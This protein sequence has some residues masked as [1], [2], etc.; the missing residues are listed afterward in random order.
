MFSELGER[1]E[2]EEE[3]EEEEEIAFFV[4]ISGRFLV[5]SCVTFCA[6]EVVKLVTLS[7]SFH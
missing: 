6:R 7:K 3:E 2:E 4:V 5:I 1:K